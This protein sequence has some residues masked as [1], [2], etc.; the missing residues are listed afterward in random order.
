MKT[1]IIYFVLIIIVALNFGC[2]NTVNERIF[3]LRLQKI[4]GE[5]ISASYLLPEDAYF[6]IGS[7]RGSYSIRYDV[8]SASKWRD[9]SGRILR[10]GI[11]DFKINEN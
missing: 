8:R 9:G 5:W 11:I 3:N 2:S 10:N 6:F 7:H 4:N 1:K